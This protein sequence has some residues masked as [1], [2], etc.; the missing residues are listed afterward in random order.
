MLLNTYRIGDRQRMAIYHA[1]CDL[2]KRV[3]ALTKPFQLLTKSVD[4]FT[5]RGEAGKVAAIIL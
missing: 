1:I 3:H 5:K 2:T 4:N